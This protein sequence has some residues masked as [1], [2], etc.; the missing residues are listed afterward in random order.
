MSVIGL[1]V[2]TSR[3]KAVRFDETWS[4]VDTAAAATVVHH[5]PG[6]A[7]EQDMSQ[8]WATA[9]Q[10]VRTVVARSPDP[11]ES[12]AV[13]AQGD[14]CWL[15]DDHAQPVGPAL[16][17]N[18]GRAAGLVE[19]W[20]TDGTAEQA[21]R[22]S[23][24]AP[25]PG[26]AHAQL[27]WLSRHRPDTLTR[28]RHLL[29]CGSWIYRQM[30]GRLVLDGTDI[31]NPLFDA[32]TRRVS[33]E[34]LDMFGIRPGLIPDIVAGPDRIA[35]L[36]AEAAR[37]TGLSAGTP[38][39]IAP[40]DVPSSAA[41]VGLH[42]PGDT[43]A[44]LGTTF[45]VAVVADDPHL[46]RAPTGFTLPGVHGNTWL[47]AHATMAGTE[48]LDWLAAVLGQPDARAV[49]QLAA[50]SHHDAPPLFAPYLSPA[51]ERSPF[52]DAAVRGTIHQLDLSHSPADIARGALEGLAFTVAD[53]LRGLPATVTRLAVCGGAARSALL[54]QILS[55]LLDRE[56]TTP[57]TDEVGARGAVL[58][59][60]ADQMPTQPLRS[61]L[62]TA[63]RPD[64]RYHPDPAAGD[65]LRDRFERM[66]DTR[67][68]L[69]LC[70]RPPMAS[71]RI[72]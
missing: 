35:P 25:A 42:R 65:R 72:A 66:L 47:L 40:Y 15:V 49:A 12:V 13:T 16:L 69:R 7:R 26:L 43:V 71:P 34:L 30:T 64:A 19:Q 1:D 44:I 18:D 54:C 63:V 51:G 5:G 55:D 31:A 6:G 38:V 45:C 62:S 52:L 32:R 67:E 24:C 56:V 41:G 28:A 2:G 14:G 10:V 48:V 9:A 60:A 22:I 33:P 20:V 53:C 23:G 27:G 37:L 58:V 8:V 29:S 57:D 46:Q 50:T 21:F 68:A 70:R 4:A 11:V 17:W 3:I 36:S 59:A 61:L 39:G